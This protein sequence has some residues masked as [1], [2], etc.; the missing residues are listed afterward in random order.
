MELIEKVEEMLAWAREKR[1][2]RQ[3]IGFVPTMGFLH[4]GHLSLMEYAR[5][6]CDLLTASI[7][8]N[9]TQFA[10]TEDFAEYPRDLDR[11]LDLMRQARVDLVF[12]PTAAEMYAEGFQ[13]FVEVT[14]VSQGLCGIDRPTFFRGVATVVAKLFNIVRPDLAV[15]GE[16]DY[17]QLAV[18]KR[19]VKDLHMEVEV[20]GRPTVREEDGLAMS[21]RNIY[22][23]PEE[24][25]S[26]LSLN[27]SLSLAQ[28]M[29]DQG[30]LA[31]TE[32]LAAVKKHIE[33]RPFTRIQYVELVDHQTLKPVE[34]VQGRALL[35]MA[36]MVGVTRLID[37]RIITS[38]IV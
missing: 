24:R 3:T 23:S 31:A 21:S 32:I 19:M 12:H 2:R 13:T 17:Q 4:H 14:D 35:A 18:I 8:V 11:D 37:N 5:P 25:K 33:E 28:E 16:K 27:T 20:I 6:K 30:R 7:F 22:L 9:P 36:V 38:N 34:M 26:A 1:A 29:V 15:F 10:P